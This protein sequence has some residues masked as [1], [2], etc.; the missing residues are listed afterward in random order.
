MRIDDP[1][2]SEAH[3]LVSLRGQSLKLL[4]L[5]GRIYL[6]QTAVTSLTLDPGTVFSLGPGLDFV[7]VSVQLPDA[8][9]AV[10]GPGLARQPLGGVSSLFVRPDPRIMPGVADNADALIWGEDDTWWFRSADIPPIPVTPGDRVELGDFSLTFVLM[11]L[12]TASER[13]TLAGA[14]PLRIVAGYDTVQVHQGDTTAFISGIPARIISELIEY[15]V[16]A[17]W[18]NIAETLWNAD[19]DRH[20]LRARFDMALSRL[21]KKLRDAGIRDDFIV[22]SGHGHIELVLR[23]GDIVENRL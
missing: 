1:R 17:E 23:H 20:N 14:L 10:E 2:V 21:R 15:G 22:T 6:G 11:P 7:V 8:V 18:Q 5:R 9:L 3:A 4:G 16:A 19:Q 12:A 13:S